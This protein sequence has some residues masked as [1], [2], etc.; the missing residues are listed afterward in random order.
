MAILKNCEIWY[1]K[2]DPKRP[3]KTFDKENGQWTCQI[4][5]NRVEQKNEWVAAGL[6]PK[7]VVHKSGDDEGTPILDK[8]GK[9]Q[10]HC[11]LQKRCVKAS[12]EAAEP[13]KVVDGNL[14]DVDPRT[15]GN[16]S[17]GNI[18]VF[19]YDSKTREGEKVSMLM[20]IQLT[21][22]KV[23]EPRGEAETFGFEETEVIG[24]DTS[25]KES[26][27]DNFEDDGAPFDKGSEAPVN[28][29]SAPPKKAAPA[30]PASADSHPEDAF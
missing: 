12:G 1:A 7:L 9:R 15:I 24:P 4:R 25:A 30:A 16:G 13:V 28:K 23:Y 3:D 2:V 18:R 8:D 26:K 17:V 21:K 11:S 27:G 10:W 14:N 20:A 19:Q 6:K 5:T 29:P 22:H